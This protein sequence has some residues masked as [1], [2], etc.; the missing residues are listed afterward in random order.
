MVPDARYLK[1][2]PER[3]P[4][5]R[6][7]ARKDQYS[8]HTIVSWKLSPTLELP[9]V[10]ATAERALAQATPT[11]W[12]SDQG[13]RFTSQEYPALLTSAKVRISMDGR[14]RALDNIFTKRL[15]RTIK[16]EEVYLHSYESPREARQALAEYIR[17]YNTE[18]LHQ[19]LAYRPP[20]ELYFAQAPLHG[21]PAPGSILAATT[22]GTLQRASGLWIYG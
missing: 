9:F 21:A 13:S 15:W 1:I 6:T 18:R 5:E 17:F 7:A 10:L 3:S 4:L 19:S 11:I 16:Y 14:G 12:N 8:K 2:F 22:S 20:A